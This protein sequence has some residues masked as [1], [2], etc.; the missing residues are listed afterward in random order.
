MKSA[1]CGLWL[2]LLAVLFLPGCGDRYKPK[3]GVIVTGKVV[4]GGKPLDVP[5][6]DV[7]LGSVEV[8]LIPV[9]N[10]AGGQQE[11]AL[12]NEDGS[13]RMA[14]P[15]AGI[16]PGKY[17]LAVLQH[18]QGPGSDMLKGAFAPAKTPITVEVPQAKL[19]G[20]HDLGVIDLDKP[21]K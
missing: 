1:S 15:G 7:G 11:M 19:G 12:A 6:R 18:D 8:V 13:F 9:A 2:L 20:T 10:V 4:K 14:G 17:K 3:D 21:G 16:S 5:H